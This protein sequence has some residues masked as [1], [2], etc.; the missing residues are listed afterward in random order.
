MN[1]NYKSIATKVSE[2]SFDILQAICARKRITPYELLQMVLDTLIRYMDDRHNLTPEMETLIHT[3]ENLEGWQD[4]FNV[5]NP[6]CSPMISEAIYLLCD[7]GGKKGVRGVLVRHPF[8]GNADYTYNI[9]EQIERIISVLFPQLYKRLRIVGVDVDS[10]SVVETIENLVQQYMASEDDRALAELFSQNDNS[11]AGRQMAEAPY[12]K[13][14]HKS[15]ES[16]PGLFTDDN[17]NNV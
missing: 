12:K 14:H 10:K 11:E 15:P 8:F 1:Q 7:N 2:E 16:M 5:S 13:R 17:S 9:Q 6:D 3:F 4:A